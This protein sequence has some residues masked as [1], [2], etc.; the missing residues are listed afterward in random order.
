[1]RGL[2]RAVY[3]TF[4]TL[5]MGLGLLALVAPRLALLFTALFAAIHWAEYLGDRRSLLS[6]LVNT[7]PFLA[8]LAVRPRPGGRRVAVAAALVLFIGPPAGLAPA[9]A[10]D[11]LAPRTVHRRSGIALVRI[12]AGGTVAEP[13][14]L[15]ETEVTVAQFRRFVEATGYLTDAE[16]GAD[17]GGHGVGAFATTS[18]G[19]REWSAAASWRRPFPDLPE[20]V[21]RDYQPVTQVSWNDAQAFCAH[22]GLRLPTEEEWE[23]AFRAGATAARFPW[24]EPD[25]VGLAEGMGN[26][27]D[28]TSFQR[29]PARNQVF[30]FDDRFVTLAP[31]GRFRPNLWGVYDLVGN[32]QEWVDARWSARAP[33]ESPGRV[34]RGCSWLDGPDACAYGARFALDRQSRRDFIGFRAAWTPAP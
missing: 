27:T 11:A 7:V 2:A 12:P 19:G 28:A 9:T 14:Y 32:V 20:H 6:P 30:P 17:D 5:A 13:F 25:A 33:E 31:A 21:S 4:G 29:F 18:D 22:Y 10:A 8:L 34:L 16:R 3:G 23:H 24:G 26:V 1:M 15:G